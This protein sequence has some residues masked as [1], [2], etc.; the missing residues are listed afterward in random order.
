MTIS[1][2]L[3]YKEANEDA[4]NQ[5]RYTEVLIPGLCGENKKV[6]FAD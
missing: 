5:L 3:L 1:H 4:R 6:P 2:I